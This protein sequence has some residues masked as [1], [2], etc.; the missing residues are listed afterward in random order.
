MSQGQVPPLWRGGP[1]GLLCHALKNEEVTVP[2]A[3][4]SSGAIVQPKTE[5]M[6]ATHT[7]ILEEE[8]LW[9]AEEAAAHAQNV[10]AELGL[11]RALPQSLTPEVHAQRVIAEPCP[12]SGKL[13]GLEKVTHVQPI[14]AEPDLPGGQPGDPNV[15]AH[16]HLASA[17]P[18]N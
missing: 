1:L 17:E 18:N 9:I 6:E 13:R 5:A 11:S 8:G 15:N 16:T 10:V 3:E 4:A 14:A 12:I 7:I 2:A